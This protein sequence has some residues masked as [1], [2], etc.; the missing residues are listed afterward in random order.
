MRNQIVIP[1]FID[2]S[3]LDPT[4]QIMNWNF[5]YHLHFGITLD[6]RLVMKIK[7]EKPKSDVLLIVPKGLTV[8]QVEE[9]LEKS[10][11]IQRMGV[12]L[13]LRKYLNRLSNE[14]RVILSSGKTFICGSRFVPERKKIAYL[15]RNASK[16]SYYL[17][18]PDN[19]ESGI[20]MSDYRAENL[21]LNSMNYL[22]RLLLGFFLFDIHKK[23]LDGRTTT[24]CVGSKTTENEVPVIGAQDFGSNRIEFSLVDY[25]KELP[26]TEDLI[27]SI[28]PVFM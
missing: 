4:I 16:D 2:K 17:W 3:E 18:T 5:F 14:S 8:E 28:R 1:I 25:T 12:D 22:E 11:N 26:P 9:E 7:Q 6:I 21:E 13:D 19:R 20:E 15:S 10:Y 23:F 24:L 27:R